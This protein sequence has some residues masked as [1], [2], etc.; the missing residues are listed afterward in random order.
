MMI[1]RSVSRGYRDRGFTL[2]EVLLVLAILGAM[3]SMVVPKLLGR[4]QHANVDT[5][6]ISIRGVEQA[7]KLYALDHGGDYPTEAQGLDVL[8]R[9]PSGNDVRWKGPYLDNQPTDGWGTSLRYVFPGR[10]HA[11]GFDIVSPGPD[12]VFDTDDDIRNRD[13]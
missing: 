6:R 1:R 2:I 12:R 10:E 11:G 7:L 9:P 13:A 3:M 5:T 4:Q 8:V